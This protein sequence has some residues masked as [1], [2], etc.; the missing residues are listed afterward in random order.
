M[1]AGKGRNPQVSSIEFRGLQFSG[2]LWL[3]LGLWIV[4]P[5]RQSAE[6]LYL[7]FDGISNGNHRFEGIV[8]FPHGFAL[9]KLRR[10]DGGF[11]HSHRV[12]KEEGYG[13]GF[14]EWSEAFD[15]ELGFCSENLNDLWRRTLHCKNQQK[16]TNE[17]LNCHDQTSKQETKKI[18]L[19]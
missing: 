2:W 1:I 13:L 15:S 19:D 6:L 16:L 7:P 11:A 4:H 17:A 18:K 12:T 3:R 8:E 10:L 5:S 14:S 9:V